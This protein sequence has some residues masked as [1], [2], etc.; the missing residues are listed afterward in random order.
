MPFL[1]DINPEFEKSLRDYWKMNPTLPGM[2]IDPGASVWSDVIHCGGGPPGKFFSD[3]IVSSLENA[4]IPILRKTLMPIAKIRSKRLQSVPPPNYYVVETIPG[5]AVDYDAMG[6]E[7][8][9]DGKPLRSNGW[10]LFEAKV[11]MDLKTWN[12]LDLFSFSNR[13]GPINLVCTDRLRQL[14]EEEGW[15]NVCFRPI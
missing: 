1:Q 2:E 15:T 13:G 4:Q 8:D 5:M 6:I 10:K 11:V 12:G 3:K 9:E 14:A 7:T